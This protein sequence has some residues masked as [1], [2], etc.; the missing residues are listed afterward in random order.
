MKITSIETLRLEE[1]GNLIWVHVK[2]DDGLVG[3]GETFFGAQAVESWLHET[4]A[5]LLIGEDPRRIEY[6]NRKLQTYTGFRGSGAEIRGLSAVD[7]ALWDLWGKATD[8][9]MCQLMG[10]RT[11]DAVRTYNTCAGYQYIRTTK[12]QDSRNWGIDADRGAYEDLDAF[13]NRADELAE[14]LLS[15]GITAMKIWPLD[16]YAEATGG[17]WISSTDIRKGLEPFEK[18]RRAVGDRIEVMLECH[19]LWDL[20]T[21]LR[22]AERVKEFDPL[23]VEDPIRADS[24]AALSD[25]RSKSGV[26]VTA[27]EPIAGVWGAKDLIDAQAVDFVML[28][29]GWIGGPNAKRERQLRWQQANHLPIA[30]HDCTGPVVYTASTHLSVSAPNAVIQESVRAFYTGWYTEVATALP[31]VENGFVRPPEGPGLGMSLLPDI[32]RRADAQIR[33]TSEL[34]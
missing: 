1:F 23:W 19:G 30:P 12:G 9:P 4:A 34:D 6:L 10:G 14:D 26:R 32:Y 3:L 11:R 15:Q 17:S 31:I 29:L 2:V 24:V 8:Q 7:I 27:S 21:S 33:V 25:Y 20:P 22:I 5:P 18:I 13:L 16:R 28:D